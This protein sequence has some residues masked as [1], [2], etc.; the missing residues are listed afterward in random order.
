MSKRFHSDRTYRF[1]LISAATI[2]VVGALLVWAWAVHPV[3]DRAFNQGRIMGMG[4]A[5]LS[6]LIWVVLDH[7]AD[8]FNPK[9]GAMG[10]VLIAG[11]VP[12]IATAILGVLVEPTH[13]IQ[14]DAVAVFHEYTDGE[15]RGHNVGIPY[16]FKNYVTVCGVEMEDKSLLG[17]VDP[18]RRELCLE[19][20]L[21]R[22]KGDEVVG[23]IG[24]QCSTITI[25]GTT[26]SETPSDPASEHGRKLR[27]RGP[28]IHAPSEALPRGLLPRVQDRLSRLA[29]IERMRSLF[30]RSRPQAITGLNSHR[31]PGSWRGGG[32]SRGWGRSRS[33]SELCSSPS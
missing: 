29:P 1:A 31:W 24:R 12:P 3:N 15:L 27:E 19:I 20:D 22:E 21:R 10:V 26:A 5:L 30:A 25:D 11:A 33:A 7:V 9:L 17:G 4:W 13:Q 32:P 14:N 28:V 8:R 23:A 2:G 16:R 6:L 18:Y